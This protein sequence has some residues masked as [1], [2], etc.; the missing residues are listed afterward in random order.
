MISENQKGSPLF[1]WWGNGVLVLALLGIAFL[2]I[3]FLPISYMVTEQGNYSYGPAAYVTYASIAVYLVLVVGTVLKH[4]EKLHSKKRLVIFLAMGI[5]VAVSLYQAFVPLALLSG[6][7]IML[8]VLS[9]Y[10]LMENPD[11]RLADRILEEKEKADAA[12]A[13]KSVFLSYVSHEIRTPMNAI[14]GMTDVLLRTDMDEEQRDYLNNIKV[15]G[16]ALVFIINNLLDISKIEAG[17]MEIV[18]SKY[19]L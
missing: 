10:F 7:G 2:G 12:N 13:S 14:L 1:C 17:K 9:L 19:Q 5:E 15:S 3:A 16:D 11:I 18:N 6:M 4:R 8:I